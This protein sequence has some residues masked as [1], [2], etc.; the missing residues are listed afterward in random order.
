MGITCPYFICGR[1]KKLINQTN[2]KRSSPLEH[3]KNNQLETDPTTKM[4]IKV[5][6]KY[7]IAHE[8]FAKKEKM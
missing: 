3:K 7:M 8:V 1:L 4:F 2:R 5:N 6:L